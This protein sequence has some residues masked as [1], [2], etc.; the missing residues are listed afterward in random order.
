MFYESEKVNV[1]AYRPQDLKRSCNVNITKLEQN[2]EFDADKRIIEQVGCVDITAK[3]HPDQ[4]TVSED[5][6]NN[7]RRYILVPEIKKYSNVLH[8][9]IIE[10]Q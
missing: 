10:N 9:K 4:H 1:Q 3:Y 6:L 8:R 2:E 7:S 5:Q